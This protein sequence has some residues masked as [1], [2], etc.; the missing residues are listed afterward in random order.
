MEGGPSGVIPDSSR[1]NPPIVHV[2]LARNLAILLHFL[3]YPHS[4]QALRR[5]SFSKFIFKK[6]IECRV[7]LITFK[8]VR[9]LE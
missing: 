4:P 9:G 5:R 1:S 2:E 7:F 8:T 6:I 3:T